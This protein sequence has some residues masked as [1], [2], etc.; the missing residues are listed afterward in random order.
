M[1]EPLNPEDLSQ[2]AMEHATEYLNQRIIRALET[3][4]QA[5]IP[6]DFAARV[7]SQLPASRPVSLTPTY[8]GRY[9]MLIGT[10]GIL[11]A[12]LILALHSS[13]PTFGLLESLLFAQFIALALW[14]TVWRYGLR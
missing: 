9:A 3:A 12:L 7:A 13:H 10:V 8:Y 14:L 5:Q 1:H 6:T 4:P 2:S 11:A